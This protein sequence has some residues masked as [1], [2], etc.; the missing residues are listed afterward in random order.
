MENLKEF[1][2]TQNFSSVINKIKQ[3]LKQQDLVELNIGV[4][5][6]SGS[7]KSSFVNAIRG[8]GDDDEGS[9]E[10]GVVETTMKPE[11]YLHPKYKHV[12]L[13]DLPGIGTPNFKA[14]Q[15]LTKVKFESYDFFII[16]ASDRFKQCHATLAKDIERMGKKF[17]FVR[18][19]ID[20]S[21]SAEKNKKSFVLEK[22]LD[23]IQKDCEN[24]LRKAG[25]EEPVVFLISR[26]EFGK[27][28]FDKLHM[29]M[30]EEL[31]K[32]KRRVLLLSLPNITKE[33]NEKKKKALEE[34]IK[35]VALLSACAAAVPVPGLS[36]AV[37][38]S[39]IAVEL[40]K[41]YSAFD[42]DDPSLQ[43]IS[44]RS[45]KTVE[46]LKSLMKSPLRHGINHPTIIAMLSNSVMAMVLHAAGYVLKYIPIIGS[47]AAGTTS[48]CTVTKM[49]KKALNDIV[50]DAEQMLT[51]L[52]KTEV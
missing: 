52:L 12:K 29:R 22:T 41:Y 50:E 27:Y 44:E 30:E 10:T 1:V 9:A 21:I 14:E 3:C 25:I 46:E 19:K 8:L 28:D 39:I 31:P 34:N 16:I 23:S 6:E 20:L 2:S 43:L 40:K 18:S 38:L 32:H 26:S 15:Y 4:T 45:G 51:V 5:G 49:L 48:F 42:L 37:D 13:W 11:V 24:G 17:Y 33:I 35:Y 7:G 36:I 47:V